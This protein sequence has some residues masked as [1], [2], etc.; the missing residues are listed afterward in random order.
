[1]LAL[2]HAPKGSRW[3]TTEK[4]REQLSNARHAEAADNGGSG[5]P[6]G[7][8]LH[9]MFATFTLTQ[10]AVSAGLR[11]EDSYSGSVWE[12]KV[13]MTPMSDIGQPQIRA[14]AMP[15]RSPTLQAR[16]AAATLNR[17]GPERQ[18][19]AGPQFKMPLGFLQECPLTARL[20][21]GGRGT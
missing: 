17:K 18:R 12:L 3:R 10:N 8:Q 16:V 6:S 19:L 2:A 4:K 9:E 13:P 21:G 14:C 11:K 15:W 7:A 1:V 20:R 5:T